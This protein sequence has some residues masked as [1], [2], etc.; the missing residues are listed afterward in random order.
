MDDDAARRRF[1]H[2]GVDRPCG[3][4]NIR[5][6]ARLLFDCALTDEAGSQLHALRIADGRILR[7]CRQKFE[8]AVGGIIL[9]DDALVRIDE[10]NK[11]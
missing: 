5:Q 7:E 10:R 2:D 8:F 11:L 1:E 9:I 3:L 6:N 4:W